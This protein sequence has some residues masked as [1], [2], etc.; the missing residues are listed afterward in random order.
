MARPIR[1]ATVYRDSHFDNLIA[2]DMSLIRWLR[3]SEAFADRGYSVDMIVNAETGL[4]DKA[5]LQYVKYGQVDWSRYDVI[6]TLFHQGF[7]SLKAAGG[8]RHPFIISKLGSVVGSSDGT[9]GV[10]FFGQEREVLFA[11]QQQINAK[12]RYI[13]ALTSQSQELWKKEHGR[14]ERMLLVPTGVD[15]EIPPPGE[16]PYRTSDQNIAVY[17]GNI[18][19]GFQREVNLL[20]Q[21]RL[22]SL[23]WLLRKKGIRL[24][25]VGPGMTD[26]LDSEAVTAT[27]PVDDRRVWDYQYFASVG[28]VLGQG[29][30]QH[31]ESSKIY[32]Y[33]RTGLPVVSEAPVPNNHIIAEANLG[34]IS[35]YHDDQMMA[36]MVEAAACKNWDR[37]AAVNYMLK[38]HT[39]DK[40]VEIYDRLIKQELQAD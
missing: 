22:N 5:N 35:N 24:F 19:E 12:S 40:R 14:S 10:H 37:A 29:A 7:D 3:I 25:F 9:E 13:T 31:N 36:D 21:S 16:N 4:H 32:Y 39:W 34:F 11:T 23:G 26:Q 2:S 20:W 17:I 33:L 15:S 1:I 30:M 38:N 18:Y 27:G 8:D 6:K 28:I